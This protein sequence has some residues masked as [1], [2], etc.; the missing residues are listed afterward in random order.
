MKRIHFTSGY[1]MKKRRKRME[2]FYIGIWQRL[3]RGKRSNQKFTV[4]FL[5]S[6]PYI[7]VHV[8]FFFFS[9]SL[10]VPFFASH[11]FPL[12]LFLFLYVLP[13]SA[14]APFLFPIFLPLHAS[15]FCSTAS[16]PSFFIL[17]SQGT[18]QQRVESRE[19]TPSFS[20][21]AQ[22]KSSSLV[23]VRPLLSPGGGVLESRWKSKM[24]V[25]S[26]SA[27]HSVSFVS[28][29]LSVCLYICVFVSNSLYIFVLFSLYD[30]V[31]FYLSVYGCVFLFLCLRSC[32]VSVYRF[33]FFSLFLFLCLFFSYSL[34]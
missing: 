15:Y 4:I 20:V 26:L 34:S 24:C 23:Y 8:S 12:F 33:V 16:L 5:F 18:S 22:T 25:L 27:T 14:P 9:L 1:I 3:K 10:S 32:S 13:T 21:L 6:I 31:S 29:C 2:G 19:K 17:A 28:I 7:F 30:F 11:L